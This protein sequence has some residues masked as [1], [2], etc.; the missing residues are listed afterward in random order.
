MVAVAGRTT[1]PVESQEDRV[2]AL[3]KAAECLLWAQ[4]RQNTSC[5]DRHH[6]TAVGVSCAGLH[7]TM[8]MPSPL[9]W[10]ARP[11][12]CTWSFRVDVRLSEA[13]KVLSYDRASDGAVVVTRF[14]RGDWQSK[15]LAL[16]KEDSS[17]RADRVGVDRLGAGAFVAFQRPRSWREGE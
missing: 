8:I 7:V 1:T 13:G 6:A 4:G 17:Q 14:Q 12:R 10:G 3:A 9:S 2:A 5:T 11:S 15:L 16:G